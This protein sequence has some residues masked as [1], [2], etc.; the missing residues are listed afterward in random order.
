M[1]LTITLTPEVEERLRQAAH[2]VGMDI[3]SY[4]SRLLTEELPVPPM[5]NQMD[6]ATWEIYLDELASG[7]EDHLVLP[8][9]A[10]SRESIYGDHD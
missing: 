8:D 5:A 4:V 1:T 9:E 2:R 7:S 10:F 3:N 6:V